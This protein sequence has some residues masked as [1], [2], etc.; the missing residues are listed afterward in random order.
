MKITNIVLV[1]I[2]LLNGLNKEVFALYQNHDSRA[3]TSLLKAPSRQAQLN[4]SIGEITSACADYAEGEIIVKMKP[5]QASSSMATRL[6]TTG[7][8]FTTPANSDDTADVESYLEKNISGLGDISL[9]KAIKSSDV[10]SGIPLVNF[11]ASSKGRIV[12]TAP[13]TKLQLKAETLQQKYGFDRTYKINIQEKDCI[14]L[15]RLIKQIDADPNVEYAEA[16]KKVKVNAIAIA[17][18]PLY[19]SHGEVWGLPYDELWGLKQIKADQAWSVSS[20]KGVVVAVIDTGVDYNHPDL[21]DNIWVDPNLVSDRNDDGKINLD[22]ADLD[23][24]QYIS[25]KEIIPGM[26]GYDFAYDDNDPQDGFGHGTHVAGTIAAVR[27]NAKG[28]VGVA[29]NAKILILKGL[30]DDGSGTNDSLANAVK[31][32]ADLLVNNAS[33]S[34]LVTNNSWGGSGYSQV[35][36]DVFDY[37]KELGVISVVAAGNSSA[38]AKDFNPATLPSVITVAASTVDSSLAGFSNF[39]LS[40]DVAA[41]G[42]G[43]ASDPDERNILSTMNVNSAIANQAPEWIIEND[44]DRPEYAYVR[45]AGTSMA[46]PHIAGVVAL[47]KSLHPDYNLE[48]IRSILRNKVSP[49]NS[50]KIETGIL[51][52]LDAVRSTQVPAKAFLYPVQEEY[53]TGNINLKGTASAKN[54]VSYILEFSPD[55]DSKNPNWYP[56]RTV[57]KAVEDGLIL[58]NFDSSNLPDGKLLIR[59]RVQSRGEEESQDTIS[60]NVDNIQ[61]INPKTNDDID[62][63]LLTTYQSS[64]VG[65]MLMP[66]IVTNYGQTRRPLAINVVD[67]STGTSV[68]SSF[69][70]TGSIVDTIGFIDTKS[71]PHSGAYNLQ[72][73][74]NNRVADS[75]Y[76]I[77]EP[78]LVNPEPMR[79]L[80]HPDSLLWKNF[81]IA[82]LNKDGVDEIFIG[83][84]KIKALSNN[85]V[86][87][88]HTFGNGFEAFG[89]PLVADLDGDGNNELISLN[90][91]S[92]EPVHRIS[93]IDKENRELMQWER[94]L[95]ESF[96]ETMIG[97]VNADGKS[98][99]LTI[100]GSHSVGDDPE[101]LDVYLTNFFLGSDKLVHQESHLLIEDHVYVIDSI[102]GDFDANGK[103]ELALLVLNST[104]DKSASDEIIMIFSLTGKLLKTI[105]TGLSKSLSG[106]IA[107]DLDQDSD[108]EF[109]VGGDTS[110][111]HDVF[112]S[113]SRILNAFNYDGSIVT[114]WPFIFPEGQWM[115]MSHVVIGD[116]NNDGFPEIVFGTHQN[117]YNNFIFDPLFGMFM[118][119]DYLF[120][121]D[122]DGQL[123][124]NYPVIRSRYQDPSKQASIDLS[125]I[126]P[127]CIVIA[128][129]DNDGKCDIVTAMEPDKDKREVIFAYKDDGTLVK[130]FP[131]HAANVAWPDG[132][133]QVQ[134]N[135]MAVGNFDK[136]PGL[137]LVFADIL[138]YVYVYDLNVP[139]TAKVEWGM[140]RSDV[141]NTG[142][143][144]KKGKPRPKADL[145]V[146]VSIDK[147]SITTGDTFTLGLQVRNNL[148][149]AKGWTGTAYGVMASMDI[150]DGLSPV[151]I[152]THCSVKDNKLICNYETMSPGLI[153]SFN[154]QFKATNNQLKDIE[155]AVDGASVSATSKLLN[156]ISIDPDGSNNIS[157]TVKIRV[158]QRRAD[159]RISSFTTNKTTYLKGEDVTLTVIANNNIA[160]GNYNAYGVVLKIP[161]PEFLIF[162]PNKQDPGQNCALGNN[163]IVC[164]LLN[165]PLG[166]IV[167]RTIKFSIPSNSTAG[168]QNLIIGAATIAATNIVPSQ[169]TID[170]ITVNNS[171][172]VKITT[173][174]YADLVADIKANKSSYKYNENIALTLSVQNKKNESRFFVADAFNV[175]TKMSIP[176]SYT[177]AGDNASCYMDIDRVLTCVFALVKSAEIKSLT[178]TLKS[179]STKPVNSVVN[180]SST[181]SDITV[182]PIRKSVDPSTSN[183]TKSVVLTVK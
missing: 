108:L 121:L 148:N 18:D 31:Y 167:R 67:L 27:S 151:N 12:Q 37:A 149:L 96:F 165:L 138:K 6:L 88:E 58:D 120:A 54:F 157:N 93:V 89:S 23:G 55:L 71:L 95:H 170:P 124:P 156:Q 114:G 39:G 83:E 44:E 112:G 109:I 161:Q 171:A 65:N 69:I 48:D 56:I 57:Y 33:I 36:A 87:L 53:L 123:L 150:P 51:N 60:I 24:D 111:T 11:S 163:E 105:H 2:L 25:S 172:S 40:V 99:I 152:D 132:F 176:S 164:Q 1:L 142:V 159:L 73:V 35:F 61:L 128:D 168:T 174:Q 107:A 140:L 130:G 16:N 5:A 76:F 81:K 20:G 46:S 34:S 86:I 143:Y 103:D 9:D 43:D 42:G 153:K 29:P 21:W 155:I 126:P 106:L 175:I 154:I 78:H 7:L 183:N 92:K 50:D 181:V 135:S 178:F 122:K 141:K 137:E 17:N 180:F 98:D 147:S 101:M 133:A 91:S 52:A 100:S 15:E 47:I 118:M 13:K 3:K 90:Y 139:A 173:I 59:L 19:L 102:I 131:F 72:I 146:Q 177:Y 64:T 63:H 117:S 80:E 162:D 110:V 62:G 26:F 129:V 70:S 134:H 179:L 84:D 85:K 144:Y 14:R 22:D 136:D 38:D 66:V 79:I 169:F 49:I 125:Y 82:D 97:D 166:D 74:V 28:I 8:S 4:E 158:N 115:D 94:Y 32:A 127:S 45:I 41:P 104:S 68:K 77:Y 160:A 30:D 116:L 75:T 119:D 182:A 10:I 113:T 145:S